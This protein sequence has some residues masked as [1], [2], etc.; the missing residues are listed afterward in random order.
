MGCTF[1]SPCLTC[2]FWLGHCLLLPA[3]GQMGHQKHRCPADAEW[4][5]GLSPAQRV[6]LLLLLLVRMMLSRGPFQGGW[7]RHQCWRA[8]TSVKR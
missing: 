3:V 5:H 2:C 6:L 8:G 1:G 7:R 4:S